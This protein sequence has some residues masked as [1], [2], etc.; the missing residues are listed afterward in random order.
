MLASRS[1]ARSHKPLL[2]QGAAALHGVRFSM[3][4]ISYLEDLEPDCSV[5]EVPRRCRQHL[6][7]WPRNGTSL[8]LTFLCLA[9]RG[10]PGKAADLERM[11]P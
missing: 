4:Q 2:D 7:F 8:G 11:R 10:G 5:T 6:C 3:I 1:L 9:L